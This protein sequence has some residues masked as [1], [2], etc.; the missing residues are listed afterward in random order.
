MFF[1]I[2][3]NS[4]V[5]YLICGFV[6][7]G[8]IFSFNGYFAS[9]EVSVSTNTI[10]IDA[11]HGGEDGGAIGKN[12]TK[13]KD[14][15]LSISLKLKNALIKNGFNV[16]MTRETDT[17]L[18]EPDEKKHKKRSDLN[19]RVKMTRKFENG[20]FLSIHM[21]Y[22]DSPAQ[23]GAQMFYSV[24]NEKSKLLAMCIEKEFKTSVDPDNKRV[25]K[26]AGN[27]IFIMKHIKLPACL[28]ECGFISN[29]EEEKLLNDAAY[30]DKIVNAIVT[31]VKKYISNS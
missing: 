22:Y 31:G 12:G 6:F 13:E 9:R 4:V 14:L 16:Q 8:V 1:T 25:S 18:S 24:N 20:I 21:N 29:R 30:Q 2:N 28:I 11:G 7:L 5:F 26:P 10:I 23:K 19:N 17:M 27:E 15:N 3:K